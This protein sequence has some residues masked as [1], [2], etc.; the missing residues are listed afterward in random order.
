MSWLRTAGERP[1]P[2]KGWMW[3]AIYILGGMLV[4]RGC[5]PFP[6]QVQAKAVQP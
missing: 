1:I 3:V 5:A 6:P 4:I 2:A